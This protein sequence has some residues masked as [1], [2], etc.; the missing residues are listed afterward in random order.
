MEK[1]AVWLVSMSM[2]L[3]FSPLVNAS[4]L[5]LGNL[6]NV[7]HAAGNFGVED[8]NNVTFGVVMNCL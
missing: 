5:F 2:H 4:L 6:F 7:S 8:L 3:F 1:I